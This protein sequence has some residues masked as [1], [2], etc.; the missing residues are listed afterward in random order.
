MRKQY[1][2]LTVI[3]IFSSLFAYSQINSPIP[4]S[5][6]QAVLVLTA[7][8]ESNTGSMYYFER[9]DSSSEWKTEM[10]AIPIAIGR[11]GLGW[12]SGLHSNNNPKGFP[13]KKEGDGKSPAGVF[14]LSSI[15]GY[16]TANE[17]GELKMPYLQLNEMI[18]CIDDAKSIHY[19]TLVS[20]DTLNIDWESSEKMASMGIYYELGVT[21]DHNTNPVKNGAGSCIFIHNWAKPNG[22]TAGCTAMDPENMVKTAFWLDQTKKPILIQLT[23]SRY[24][25]LINTWAL[26]DILQ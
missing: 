10:E 7:S 18:E 5:C 6:Q 25:K 19:N 21:V 17:I 9:N 14:N 23:K 4:A 8:A 3:I 1:L 13:I 24:S 22:T 2:L 11:N 15:F 12:G 16:K 26:P 20:N